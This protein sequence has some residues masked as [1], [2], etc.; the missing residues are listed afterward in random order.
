MLAEV[1]NFCIYTI[2]QSMNIPVSLRGT[3]FHGPL[4]NMT[5]VMK[6]SKPH[7]NYN[8]DSLSTT[9]AC[10]SLSESTSSI[11]AQ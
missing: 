2:F 3:F 7:G 5:L 4:G 10:P 9:H 1:F 11:T 8:S 6:E